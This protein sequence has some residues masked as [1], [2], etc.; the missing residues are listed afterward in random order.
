MP[1]DEKCEK[2]RIRH[3]PDSMY[4]CQI[5]HEYADLPTQSHPEREQPHPEYRRE[6]AQEQQSD[7]EISRELAGP[8]P[9]YGQLWNKQDKEGGM[10]TEQQTPFH[11]QVALRQPV[12]KNIVYPESESEQRV[13]QMRRHRL[14][15]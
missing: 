13:T 5:P 8:L 14:V 3:V 9:K 7:K 10:R 2:L 11:E 15:R 1:L 6:R 4:D 12:G